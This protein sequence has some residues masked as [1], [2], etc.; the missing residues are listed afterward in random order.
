MKNIKI[1]CWRDNGEVVC[2]RCGSRMMCGGY[3]C[4][5]CPNCD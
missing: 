2:D 1:I 4:W 3:Q 5:Y